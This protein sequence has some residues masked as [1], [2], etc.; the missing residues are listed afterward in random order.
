[1]TT[2]KE[3]LNEEHTL[4]WMLQAREGELKAV[5]SAMED[6]AARKNIEQ[7]LRESAIQLNDALIVVRDKMKRAGFR[8]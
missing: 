7:N 8:K 3:M 5:R 2:F 4:E 6:G 1:M